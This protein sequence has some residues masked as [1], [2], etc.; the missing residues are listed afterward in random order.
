M[1]S[2]IAIFAFALCLKAQAQTQTSEIVLGEVKTAGS[3][4][5]LSSAQLGEVTLQDGVFVFPAIL[6]LEKSKGSF[7]RGTCN[8]ALPIELAEGKK[9]VLSDLEAIASTE[10][11]ARSSLD[12]NMEVFL[13]GGNGVLSKASLKSRRQ[14]VSSD[15]LVLQP[16]TVLETACGGSGILRINASALIKG[17]GKSSA[18]LHVAKM[19]AALVSCE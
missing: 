7:G 11:A 1:K 8:L 12:I 18:H 2:T 4:C 13:A 9:L 19:K 10:L 3:A 5:D 17:N 15:L 6:A 16:G 14:S